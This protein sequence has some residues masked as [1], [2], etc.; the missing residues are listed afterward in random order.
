MTTLT[1]AEVAAATGGRFDGMRDA[2]EQA[3]LAGQTLTAVTIDSRAAGP[4]T[5]FAALPGERVDGHDYAADAVGRGAFAVLAGRPV[6][7]P[8]VVVD[9]VTAALGALASAQLVALPEVR[10]VALTGSSGKTSTKDLLA[11]VLEAA[12]PTVAPPGSYNNDLG[13][14]LTVLRCESA[15]R[16][17]VLE[18]GA[19][20][21]GHI[22]RL[23]AM[24]PPSVGAVLNIG[25]AH[26][27][28]F[29][30]R[31]AIAL[32][33]GEL[34]EATRDV[35]LLNADDALVLAMRERT[36]A[37]V[38]TFGEAGE[39][40]V[41]AEA[42]RLGADGRARFLL[43]AGDQETEVELR[44]V[45]EHQVGNALAAAAAGLECGLGPGAVAAAL[46]AAEPRSR[47]RMEVATTAGG[48]T[49]VNDAYNA[50]PESVRAA[51]KA[52]AAMGRGDGG[53]GPRHR[54]WAVLGEM[55][56]LGEASRSEHD[57]VGRYAVRLDVSR[58][59]AVGEAAKAT[60][61]GAVLEGSWGEES[62]HV[63][64]VDAAV[65]LLREQL[66]PG[67]VVLVKGSRVAGLERVAAALLAGEPDEEGVAG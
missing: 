52:L 30:S 40:Q 15:T 12:G 60:H 29:G 46:S 18:M 43:V 10:V 67:D 36:E 48:V 34:V 45:G 35:A 6:G 37:R 59:V 57:A 38:V 14:P 49:V 32:A 41:R 31:E 7:V 21:P 54:T 39:A 13:V 47:W 56:E 58:L 17:L 16:F 20:G 65:E 53:S 44:L 24:A 51:L 19:R 5:L 33:K 22:A 27:G 62:V 1:L 9:D 42:V 61:A 8:A 64:G 2:G 26:I 50:N 11:A 63:A 28:E 66:R 25:S 4:G 23:C 55:A 3:R